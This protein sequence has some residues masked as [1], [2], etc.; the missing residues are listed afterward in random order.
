MNANIINGYKFTLG[1]PICI[2]IINAYNSIPYI[3][4]IGNDYCIYAKNFNMNE[5]NNPDKLSIDIYYI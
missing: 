5:T 1:I 4:Q 3:T 2:I